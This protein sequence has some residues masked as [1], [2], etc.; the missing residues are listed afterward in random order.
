MSES[1]IE[2][3][4]D[5]NDATAPV[6]LPVGEYPAEIVSAKP[7]TSKTGN[8]YAEVGFK[9]SAD[10]YP[11]DFTEGDPD[12]ITMIYRRLSLEDNVPGRWRM[13]KF[14]S[15]IGAKSGRTIDLNDWIG[16]S[17]T[18]VVSHEEYEGEKRANIAK[19]VG[20]N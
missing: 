11:A 1:L 15:A 17:A 20:G 13:K 9:I 5:V 7:A 6:P 3:A 18:V 19:V 10:A 12:G 14:L 2:Y 16:L 4:V 8:A